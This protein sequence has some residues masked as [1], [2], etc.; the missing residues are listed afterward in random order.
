[1]KKFKY[2]AE[3]YLKFL[4]FKREEALRVLKKAEVFRD[5]LVEQYSRM[6]DQM[7]KAFQ[8]NSQLGK[9]SHSIHLVNDNNQF[10]QLLK[11]NMA[12]LSIE[13][14]HAEDEFYRKHKALLE[15][16][17][18]VK[19]MELHKEAELV[20]FKKQYKKQEQKQT[21]EINATRRRG[22]DAESL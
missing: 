8:F 13:I 7:K 17:L 6:E 10:I 2:R 11:V 9:E 21:D 18:K 15:L 14:Q 22:K 4:V 20:K 19:K 3:S 5:R 12:D 16:Q 1:M